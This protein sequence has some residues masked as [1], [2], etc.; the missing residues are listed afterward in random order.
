MISSEGTPE[1]VPVWRFW[2]GAEEAERCLMFERILAV[3]A[4]SGEVIWEK[5]GGI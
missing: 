3:N 4:I 2:P 5:R 1:I